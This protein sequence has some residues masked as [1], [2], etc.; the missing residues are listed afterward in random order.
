M[1][2]RLLSI[3]LVLCVLFTVSACAKEDGS[4]TVSETDTAIAE[5][6]EEALYQ[7]LF[8]KE[9]EIIIEV[10]ISDAEM[11]KLALDYMEYGRTG[12]KP[13]TYRMADCV[14]ITVNGVRYEYEQV[15]IRIKGNTSRSEF[16]T[17]QD[18]LYNL[19]HYRLS[20]NETFDDTEVY[21]DDALV[22]ES[23][24]ER[25]ERKNRTFATLEKLELK[26]NNS[27][28]TS[29]ISEI[30]SADMFR[31][32]GGYAQRITLCSMNF[33]DTHCGVYK[34]YEP[35]DDVFL[36]RYFGHSQ[37]NGDLYKCHWGM[38]VSSTGAWDGAKFT[39][40]MT[41]S[42][43]Q[44][45]RFCNSHCELKTNKSS[46][47]HENMTALLKTINS[48]TV[49]EE[50]LESVVDIDA[51]I[52]YAALSYIAGSPDDLRNNGNNTYVYFLPQSGKAVFITY[53]N[54]HAYYA[55]WDPTGDHMMSVSPYSVYAQGQ[56][57]IL[58]NPL[59]LLTVCAGG[60]YV[61]EY[62]EKLLEI[63]D[64]QWMEPEHIDG[65][66]DTY[67]H[68][69]AKYA[70]PD[71]CFDGYVWTDGL[72]FETPSRYVSQAYYL[73]ERKETMLQMID[74]YTAE[75]AEAEIAAREIEE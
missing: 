12:I 8:D 9:S 29:Y 19:Q 14:A 54:D 72:Y 46:S 13:Q 71:E 33:G 73:K 39:L 17:V 52:T 7:E 44:K 26:W 49:T 40:D 66:F 58:E 37:D 50:Q 47:T 25:R 4:E 28:D 15:G 45:D 10:S 21:G 55:G 68:T 3:L 75:Y 18:G 2:R 65:Y 70:R 67:R 31:A 57:E 27:Y 60:R 59:F 34:L 20:F 56:G 51:F 63:A 61:E 48:E 6:D 16:F 41:Y 53:D 43:E 35:V 1:R 38:G 24:K 22:W 30:Y 69:Y 74:N 5:I 62:R 42:V 23:D 32:F 36:R 64:S 11:K